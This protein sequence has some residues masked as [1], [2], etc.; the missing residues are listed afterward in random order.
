MGEE[1]ETSFFKPRDFEEF[2]TQL[3]AETTLLREWFDNKAFTFTEPKVG[4]ELEAWLVN[5]RLVPAPINEA[6]LKNL[7]NPCVVHELSKF[8]VELN[9]SPFAITGKVFSDLKAELERLWELCQQEAKPLG[10]QMV[11]IGMLPTLK[12]SMLSLENMST[13]KR[14]EG[15]N[16]QIFKLRNGIPISLD[17]KGEDRLQIVHDNVMLEAAA[18]SLQIHFNVPLEDSVSYYNASLILS[19]AMVALAANSPFLFGRRIWDESRIPVF[20]QAVNLDQFSDKKGFPVGRVSFGSGFLKNS[21]FELFQENLD[22]F[23]PLLPIL[24][25]RPRDHIPR[26]PRDT[27]RRRPWFEPLL[28]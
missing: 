23:S 21:F 9:T 4:F 13:S 24:F 6:F 26:S 16:E 3:R 12:P 19:P 28:A 25:P 22:R 1:I 11:M 7:N 5:K 15:L 18:T 20:E 17:V 27:V 2:Q 14:Y 10:A 8:N